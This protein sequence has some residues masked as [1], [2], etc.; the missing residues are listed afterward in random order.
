MESD[1]VG[2]DPRDLTLLQTV[3]AIGKDDAMTSVESMSILRAAAIA[4][5][6]G[7]ALVEVSEGWSKVRQVVYMARALS[8]LA[9]QR[10]ES[11]LPSLRY[12]T[13]PATP[14]NPATLGFICDVDNVG[15]AFSDDSPL[16][17]SVS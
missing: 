4:M 8:P 10:I 1:I 13:S 12:W 14:H 16:G 17:D 11:E 7:N 9:K 2:M 6:D 15:L 3:T 5:E